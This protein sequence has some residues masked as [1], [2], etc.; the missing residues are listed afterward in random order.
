MLEEHWHFNENFFMNHNV[1]DDEVFWAYKG[2]L[3]VYEEQSELSISG[4]IVRLRKDLSSLSASVRDFRPWFVT[5]Q[6]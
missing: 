1:M 5:S 6:L 4:W 3:R 2:S